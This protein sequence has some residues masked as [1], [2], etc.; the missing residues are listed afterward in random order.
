LS[1]IDD[2]VADLKARGVYRTT[3]RLDT[4]AG[5]WVT[6]EGRRMLVFGS[7]NY[8]GLATHDDVRKAAATAAMEWGAGAGAARLAGGNLEIHEALEAELADFKKTDAALL[9]SSGY[10]AALGGVRALAGESDLVL[11]DRLNHASLIDGCRL[12]RASVRV[13][14]HA[15]PGHAEELLADRRDFR[16]CLIVTDGVFSMDGDIAPLVELQ[17]LCRDRDALLFVDDA[18]GVGVIGE[19]GAGAVEHTGIDPA[20]VIQMGTLSKALGSQGGYIA[21]DG[22]TIELIRNRARSF[23]FDTAPAPAIV[24]AARKSLEILRTQPSLRARLRENVATL[25]ALLS[26]G[27]SRTS[28]DDVVPIIP[29]VVGDSATAMDLS[30]SLEEAGI[31]VPAIRPPTVPEGTARLRVTVTAAHEMADLY[32][33]G[34]A[35]AERLP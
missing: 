23:V 17:A 18:H 32:L 5:P 34:D 3:R 27:G 11:S 6:L 24:G 2:E 29:V 15:D 35:L 33:L 14:R 13:Y 20:G 19:T 28:G 22:P 7:N 30:R 16:R 9:F 26:R 8:L 4:A 31:W 10:M 21:A 1:D 25:R 12:S